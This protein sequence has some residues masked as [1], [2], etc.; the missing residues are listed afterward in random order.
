LVTRQITNAYLGGAAFNSLTNS[1]P[2]S[3][4]GVFTVSIAGRWYG[5]DTNRDYQRNNF[6][7]SSYPSQ[8]QSINLTNI[9]GEGTVNTEG[10]WRR[11]QNDWSMGSGQLFLDRQGSTSSRFYRSKGIDP[12]T[13][14]QI[15][16]LPATVKKTGYTGTLIKAI[17]ANNYVY[18][19]TD[20]GCYFTQD[21]A[22]W[23]ELK[24]GANSIAGCSD[25]TSNGRDVWCSK[26]SVTKIYH[27]TIGATATSSNLTH[28]TGVYAISW[29]ADRLLV[30]VGPTIHYVKSGGTVTSLWTHP[31]DNFL[32]TCF[33]NAQ[34][35][36]YMG[37]YS[38]TSGKGSNGSVYYSTYNNDS[39]GTMTVPISALP[40]PNGEYPTALYGYL[41]YMFVGTNRG[42]RMTQPGTGNYLTS[43]PLLPSITEPVKYPVTGITANG[44]FVYFAWNDYDDASTGI[45]RMDIS[46]FIDTLAPAYASDL[47][48]DWTGGNAAMTL[49]WDPITNG[50]LMSI[51]YAVGV[52]YGLYTQDT[53]KYVN[54]GYV[55]SGHITYGIPDDKIASFI[56][57][58]TSQSVGNVTAAVAYNR[59]SFVDVAT[60]SAPAQSTVFPVT[61][62]QRGEYFNVRLTLA[63]VTQSS[64]LTRWTLQATPTISTETKITQ[65][66][67]LSDVVDVNGTIYTYDP[68]V[69]Y[70]YLDS[71]RRQTRTI[72]YTEGPLYADVLIDDLTWLPSERR[73]NFQGGYRGNLVV[74]M[75]TVN[76]FTYNPQPTN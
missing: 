57:L 70:L 67:Q 64:T 59:G 18:V 71:I 5:V 29:Q 41:N 61:P 22:T 40:L 49:D 52:E 46:M 10:L 48:V 17:K 8:R 2:T 45:G 27:S 36:V 39:T 75:K 35:A 16:A 43:G 53:T 25:I 65:V 51:P 34:G 19:I 68:Y 63:G 32:W 20:T 56:H 21:Y 12:W 31:D 62:N 7:H 55:D 28:T 73:D 26:F 3:P 1:L 54:S 33:G 66:I 15:N 50:P 42:I 9:A 76:G 24:D 13:K 58:N 74:S 44:R 47:M 14:W 38:S 72:A 6:Q 37:G 23:T 69:E 60:M 4:Q 30:A 11:E